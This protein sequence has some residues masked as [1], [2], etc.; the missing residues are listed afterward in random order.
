MLPA[1][2]ALAVIMVPSHL[3]SNN[4][5]YYYGAAHMFGTNTRLRRY[6]RHRRDVRQE[7]YLGGAGAG[8]RHRHPGRA[9]DALHAIPEVTGILSH[10]DN[11]G[12]SIPPEFV[13]PDTLKLL[14]S[15]GYTRMVLSP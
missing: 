4:N 15:G 6:R 10:V 7:R 14:V 13:P 5:E 1:A 11:A 2:L 12:A 9:L 8:G 3:A